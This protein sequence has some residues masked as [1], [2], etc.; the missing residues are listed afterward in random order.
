[1]ALIYKR[2]VPQNVGELMDHLTYIMFSGPAFVDPHFVGR[3]LEA[4]FYEL[5]EA[6]KL[7]RNKLGEER[8]SKLAELSNRV[9][10]HYEADPEKKTGDTLKG[11]ELI[12]EMEELLK[13]KS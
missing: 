11:R 3:D 1:M 7:M 8:F 5:N 10:A 4:A 9:R 6:L 13:K 2:H 12:I